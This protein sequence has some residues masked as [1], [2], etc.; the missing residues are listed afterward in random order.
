[1]QVGPAL[2]QRGFSVGVDDFLLRVTPQEGPEEEVLSRT[3]ATILDRLP[4]TNALATMVRAGSKGSAVN[5]AQLFS[6]VGLQWVQG[7][8]APPMHGKGGSFVRS[9]FTKVP[10]R[11]PAPSSA[12]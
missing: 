6:C 9:S 11:P 1:M 8:P 3:A 12:L 2:V 10:Q 4:D 7:K 5:L